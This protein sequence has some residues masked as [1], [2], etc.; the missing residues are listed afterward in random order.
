[1]ETEDPEAEP[2]GLSIEAGA[3][4]EIRGGTFYGIKPPQNTAVGN[5]IGDGYEM[6]IDGIYADPLSYGVISGSDIVRIGSGL[7]IDEIKIQMAA[8]NIPKAGMEIEHFMPNVP[9]GEKYSRPWNGARWHDEN[10][11]AVEPSVDLHYDIGYEFEAGKS[12]YADYEYITVD[13]YVFSENPTITFIG[14]DP[15]MFTYEIIAQS[16]DR[17][18]VTVRYT[19]T[20]PGELDYPDINKV[21]MEYIGSVS[22]GASKP[23]KCK[24][25][26]NNCTIAEEEWNTGTWG[27]ECIWDIDGDTGTKQFRAGQNYVHMIRL[28]ANDGY[29]FS[30]SL[31]VQKGRQ[32][33]EEIGEVN[34][35][36]NNTVATVSYNYYVAGIEYLDT[37]TI[38]PKAGNEGFYLIRQGD[39]NSDGI[40]FTTVYT[41]D[42]KPYEIHNYTFDRWYDVE[43]GEELENCVTFIDLELGKKYRLEFT[44]H[45]KDEYEDTV[46]FGEKPTLV[47]NDYQYANAD[48]VEIET[49]CDAGSTQMRVRMTYTT[50]PKPGEGS[51]LQYPVICYTYKEFEY[52]MENKD[53]RYVA[54]G[55]VED[56]LP[57]VSMEETGAYADNRWPSIW[58]RGNKTLNLMGDAQFTAPNAETNVHRVYDCLLQVRPDSNLTIM[59]SGSLTFHGNAIGW[60]T[61]VV[62][63]VEG[64]AL[65]TESGTL[66]GDTGNRTSFCY[67]VNVNGGKL[68]ANG[69]TLI[70]TN[71]YDQ[72]PMAA[73]LLDDGIS[74]IHGGTFYSS[75]SDGAEGS[76]HYALYIDEDFDACYI[77]G[78]SF[79]GIALPSGAHMSDYVEN[80]YVMTVN[81]VKTDPATCGTIDGQIVEVYKEISNVSI[82]VNSPAAGDTPAMYVEDVWMVPAGSTVESI[83]WYENNVLWKNDFGSEQFEA[84]NTYKVEIVLTAED[85]VKFANP[86]ESATINYKTAD[87]SA[88]AGNREKGIV[89]TA[90]LGECPNSV[91]LVELNVTAPKE[92]NVISYT[93]TDN[94]DAYNAVGSGSQITNYRQW[95]ESVDGAGN[96]R[97]MESGETFKANYYYKFYVDVRTE[98]GYEYPL[99]D[100]GISIMPDVSATVNGY[101]ATVQKTI[102]QDPSRCITVEYNFGMCNDDVIEQIIIDHISAPVPG[103]TPDYDGGI[104]GNGYT[105]GPTSGNWKVNGIAWYKNDY[106]SLDYTDTFEVGESYTVYIDLVALDGY[107][108]AVDKYNTPQTSATVNGNPAIVEVLSQNNDTKHRIKYTFDWAPITIDELLIT[109]LDEPVAGATPDFDVELQNDLLYNATVTWCEYYY[110]GCT[111]SQ[112][113]PEDTFQPDVKYQAEIKIVPN[114]DAHN[115]DVCSFNLSEVSTKLNGFSPSEVY[116]S[117]KSV[118][119]YHVFRKAP[120][121]PSLGANVS[122]TVTS[123]LDDSGEVTIGLYKNGEN[124]PTY[125]TVVNG[126][127]VEYSM[128]NVV[129]GIYTLKVSKASHVTRAYEIIVDG[130]NV[131]QDVKICPLGDVDQDSDV[132]MEDVITLLNHILKSAEVTDDYA[133]QAGTVA[134]NPE[135]SMEDVIKILNYVLKVTDSLE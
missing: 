5:Y 126:N 93:V 112:L 80:G 119:I 81:G 72:S 47:F 133:I 14:P 28:V 89:M 11:V 124:T 103:E 15:S 64:G 92:G 107:T 37:V 95:M 32:S 68:Y 115:V 36:N 86:L 70:G 132:D 76:D 66:K 59:G 118:Y 88:H 52:A 29:K 82:H 127:S 41:L 123:Y 53:I 57:L 26:Y 48:F 128:A 8:E 23:D 39:N 60:P 18:R 69:G 24:M 16:N 134:G 61:A 130:Q 102:D 120:Q 94:S 135:P 108:F 79:E 105:F 22:E 111:G 38:E 21:S 25:I 129:N 6:T 131:V 74:Y 96:W 20:I 56:T 71:R 10:G 84:G 67:A 114:K 91:S 121:A 51:S 85:G 50:Q 1:M 125:S 31:I 90:D 27:S 12:Y 13:G 9:D 83:S 42:N 4:L 43:T 122:G 19:F 63:V 109:G 77:T 7:A 116:R 2:Y 87:V 58:V 33:E 3:E 54:L 101:Y 104:S 113:T 99:Y 44:V 98:D 65:I 62:T 100:N 97:V 73:V 78:G 35:S 110:E 55:N 40:P 46:R 45:I 30:D 75:V 17:T 34:L 106:N 117:S 49:D